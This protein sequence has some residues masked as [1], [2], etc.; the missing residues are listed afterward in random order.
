MMERQCLVIDNLINDNLILHLLIMLLRHAKSI[1]VTIYYEQISKKSYT[2]ITPFQFI[3]NPS[4]IF[5]S[6]FLSHCVEIYP[7]PKII[8]AL[9]RP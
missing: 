7:A 5:P 3:S 6:L 4:I 9:M 8:L 2:P 1:G